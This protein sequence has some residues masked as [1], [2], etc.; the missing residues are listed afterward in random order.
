[1]F[2]VTCEGEMLSLG[3]YQ[4]KLEQAIRAFKFHSVTRL[5]QLLGNELAA[6]VVAQGWT[7]QTVCAVPLHPKRYRE[8]G[9]NQSA[10]IARQAAKR[11]QLSYHSPLTRSRAT[12]QQA[13]LD[14]VARQRNVAGAF[15]SK[16]LTGERV[17]LIDDVVTSGATTL[18]CSLALFAAGASHVYT[19]AV[20]RAKLDR[21]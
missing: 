2:D 8:R 7:P 15:R 20:A 14:S 21:S 9:Y 13:R 12:Q 10:L 6:A 4:G 1:M 3:L 5:S 18:E 11:L 17:L 16:R 19:A